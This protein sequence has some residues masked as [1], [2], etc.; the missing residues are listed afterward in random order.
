MLYVKDC[1]R[2][3]ALLQTVAEPKHVIYNVG[4]GRATSNR[5]VADAIR[6][7]I[8]DVPLELRAGR[9]PRGHGHGISLDTARL[10]E[11]TDFEPRYDVEA[12]ATDYISWLR[13]GHDR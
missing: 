2:A 1:A 11:A 6:T 10:R 4:S 5:E 12:A 13:A 8:P 9:N 3:I 7:V